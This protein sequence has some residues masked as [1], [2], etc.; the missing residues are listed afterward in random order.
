[1]ST[2]IGVGTGGFRKDIEGMRAVA[3]IGVIAF[4]FGITQLHG[5][6]AGV[7]V[8]FVISGYL[9]T[10]HLHS[11]LQ[12]NGTIDFL[13][14]YAGRLRR[15]L[16]SAILVILTTLVAGFFFY[17]PAEQKLYSSDAFYTSAYVLNLK[18]LKNAFDYFAPE[19]ANNPYL[20]FWSLAV[21]E[22]FYLV[23]P[24]LL[25]ACFKLAPR[26]ALRVFLAAAVIG[27]F[28]GCVVV[29][30]IAQ[31][32]A[33][34]ALPFR[35][36]EFAVGASIPFWPLHLSV[37]MKRA[38]GYLGLVLIIVAYFTL[39]E[40][41]GFPGWSASIPVVGAA[42]VIFAGMDER[43]S[44]KI[45]HLKPLQ[46][47]GWLSYPL[48]L[49]HWPVIVYASALPWDLTIGDRFGVVVLTI[50]LSFASK[51][52][53]ENRV[54]HNGWLQTRPLAAI[55]MAAV[56]TLT[57]LA[58]ARA[59]GVISTYHIDPELEKIADSAAENSSVTSSNSACLP[60]LSVEEPV[61]CELGDKSSSRTI[62]LLGDSHADA[63]SNGL[64][65]F[66]K[67]NHYRLVTV[68]KASCT[69]S[70][71]EV[72]SIRF[73][74]EFFECKKWRA[75]AVAFVR[76]LKPDLVVLASFN[77]TYTDTPLF[78]QNYKRVSRAEFAQG[79]R[80]TVT[81]FTDASIPVAVMRDV[82]FMMRN[83]P[84]CLSRARWLG[85][86][87]SVCAMA[88]EKALDPVIAADER[89]A[90]TGIHDANYVDLSSSFCDD[91]ICRA[92]VGG[93][94]MFRDAHHITAAFSRALSSPLQ[95]ALERF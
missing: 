27:S 34:Y 40:E 30:R 47:A 89:N 58:S 43:S 28:L 12:K 48:Y 76:S 90:L 87:S 77:V 54:R 65:E 42:F 60:G 69:F 1:M 38:L 88:R 29:T 46:T 93:S 78:P 5:G 59:I 35:A 24:V 19:A 7:D 91:K 23:W 71:V 17:S 13:S 3:V 21:E 31:P 25:V 70:D 66:A 56:L 68:M 32:W 16:P 83:I 20:H 72:Y 74:R 79:I 95:A 18:L 14:F 81:S 82:P 10:T 22:Q 64:N 53:L 86:D 94:P 67:T 80:R 11:Q 51:Y 63:W 4:H 55:A 45:L 75:K 92:E 36:W 26:F 44:V 49:W 61:S 52:L 84:I 2:N 62:V 8:F 33:F 9:I 37:L 57:G 39:S 50:A 41:G 73:H 6:F 85:R 15:L